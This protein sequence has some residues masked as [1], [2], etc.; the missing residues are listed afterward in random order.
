[1][2]L[3]I[4]EEVVLAEDMEG[5]FS[6]A[7]QVLEQEFLEPV[8]EQAMEQDQEEEDFK[9][10]EEEEEEDFKQ[11]GLEAHRPESSHLLA[12]QASKYESNSH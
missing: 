9:Q 5:V 1:M 7:K 2:A 10:Q 12:G 6:E 8:L 3:L 4:M 11:E